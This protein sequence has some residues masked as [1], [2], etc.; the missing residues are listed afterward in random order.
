[1]FPPDDADIIVDNTA[2]G[3]T[4]AANQL[5]IVDELFKS[6]TH[7]CVHKSVLHDRVK[8][9]A[10]DEFVLLL[11]SAL[12]ARDRV[13]IEFNVTSPDMLPSII[14]K[15]PA[16]KQPTVSTLYGNSGKIATHSLPLQ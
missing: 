7:V 12:N 6:S 13:L 5:V 16:L 1:M 11:K 9:I 3:A 10:L 14:S 15:L 8:R 2:T 4:L